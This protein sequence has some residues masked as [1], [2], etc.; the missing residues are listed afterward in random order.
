MKIRQEWILLMEYCTSIEF[1]LNLLKTVSLK[2]FLML[3]FYTSAFK[4]C[5]N[6]SGRTDRES[7]WKF[8]AVHFALV[9][10]FFLLNKRL[11][12]LYLLI[13]FL[14]VVSIVTRRIR[15]AGYHPLFTLC[16]F[17]PVVGTLFALL[18]CAQPTKQ[19]AP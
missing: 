17:V 5:L 8:F 14:P 9:V 12:G 15:D 19:V 11:E 6:F 3:K 18:M 13:A 4:N 10:I 1:V 16:Q 2:A 7:F